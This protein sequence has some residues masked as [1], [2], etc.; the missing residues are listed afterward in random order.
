MTKPLTEESNNTNKSVESQ[1]NS[2]IPTTPK[3]DA[4]NHSEN[5]D[6]TKKQQLHDALLY[7]SYGMIDPKF[8]EN[9]KNEE[10]NQKADK[11]ETTQK[12]FRPNE[13]N[14]QNQL[15]I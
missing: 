5:I 4:D 12:N 15:T 11:N 2:L 10:N 7:C 6:L 3:S 9:N 14:K 8:Y 13:S 1:K